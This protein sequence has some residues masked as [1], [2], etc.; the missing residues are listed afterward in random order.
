MEYRVTITPKMQA[1]NRSLTDSFVG[2]NHCISALG[3]N[4]VVEVPKADCERVVEALKRDFRDVALIRNAYLMIPD[5]HD[6]ILVKPL[7]TESP[8][9]LCEGVSVPDL[10]KSL[11]DLSSDREYAGLRE[12]DIQAT[13]QDAFERYP[14]NTSKLLRYASRK[15]KAAEMKERLSLVNQER[16]KLVRVIQQ[17]L[18]STPVEKAWLFGSFSRREE[19]PDSDI[20]ILVSFGENTKM[21]LLTFSSMSIDLERLTGRPVDLIVDKAL[22]PFAAD[23]VNH[24]KKLI[25][26]REAF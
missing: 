23:N 16:A 3:S 11:V 12:E 19:R 14:V 8:L 13:L 9:G 6:F 1:V 7:I 15:G 10:E 22:K 2:M 4:L 24:D 25:Y 26:E 17:Y 18:V 20:D 5:L 21:G